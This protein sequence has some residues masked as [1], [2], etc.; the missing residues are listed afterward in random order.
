LKNKINYNDN[1]DKYLEYKKNYPLVQKLLP[2]GGAVHIWKYERKNAVNIFV[3]DRDPI[4]SAR[5]HCDSHIVKMPTEMAQ[6]LNTNS[7]LLGGD[8]FERD[9]KPYGKYKISHPNHPITKWARETLSNFEWVAIYGLALCEEYTRRYKKDIK[10]RR[11]IEW[12]IDFGKKPSAGPLTEFHISVKPQYI[13]D[14][15]VNSY[16]TAYCL[17][18]AS[19][20]EWNKGTKP[21]PWFRKFEKPINTTHINYF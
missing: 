13:M 8:S 19:F 20:A 9:Y 6:I 10:S 17:D 21:P 18:K 16:R 2:L 15:V 7:I 5:W 12:A 3:L 11:A 4:Q 14:D 1:K